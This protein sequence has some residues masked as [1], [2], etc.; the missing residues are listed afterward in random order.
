MKPDMAEC[1][2]RENV[3][4]IQKSNSVISPLPTI[5]TMYRGGVFIKKERYHTEK[6][7][8]VNKWYHRANGEIVKKS[9]RPAEAR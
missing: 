4:F 6:H 9:I 5:Y 7:G 1:L 3:Q 2:V 8:I